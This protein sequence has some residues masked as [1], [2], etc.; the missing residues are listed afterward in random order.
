MA[1]ATVVIAPHR[2]MEEDRVPCQAMAAAEAVTA[3]DR[4]APQV[5]AEAIRA[6]TPLAVVIRAAVDTLAVA[7]TLAEAAATLAEVVVA[8]EV[9][10]KISK[11]AA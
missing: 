1:A 2:V 3:V 10:V 4:T 11:L 7:D 8:T 9:V 6:D 5:P